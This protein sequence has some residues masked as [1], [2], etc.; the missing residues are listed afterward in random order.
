M[1]LIECLSILRY[2]TEQVSYT[3]FPGQLIMSRTVDHVTPILKV[4]HWIPVKEHL[5][6]PDAV[7]A[8]K[9]MNGMVPEYLSS[10]F[11]ARAGVSGRKTRQ[12]LVNLTFLFRT[13][14]FPI[15]YN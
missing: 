3:D 10:Q 1:Q 4:L 12:S 7:L 13:K 14:N 6:Y 8:F 11:I 9:C 5:Y 15:S 2:Y